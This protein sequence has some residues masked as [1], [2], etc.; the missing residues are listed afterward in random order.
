MKI[1]FFRNKSQLHR[2]LTIKDPKKETIY[3]IVGR[4]KILLDYFQ[5]QPTLH[6]LV[7]FLT[8]YYMVTKAAAEK[9]ILYKHFFGD[10]KDYEL[11]D[12]YFASRYFSALIKY[13]ETGRCVHPWKQY[14][15]YCQKE[16]GI[17]L[18]QILLGINAHINADLYHSLV[19]L[20]YNHRNDFFLV[21]SIL[22][23]VT[24][25]VLQFLAR[26]HDLVGISGVAFRELI[27]AEFKE[28]ILRWR[29]E[30]WDNARKTNRLNRYL[31][32][33]KIEAMTEQTALRLIE[34]F[35]NIYHLKELPRSI[36]DIAGVSVKL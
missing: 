9:Y 19:T 26:E 28:I 30:A 10:L 29:T 6:R 20:K 25:S 1:P 2:L 7:P 5:S 23:E 17:P 16:D 31:N 35:E 14:F 3:G 15:I 8:T 12:V 22:Q 32:Y 34:D 36:R 33:N 4:M 24:P 21:N 18:L 27:D 13:L 11:L